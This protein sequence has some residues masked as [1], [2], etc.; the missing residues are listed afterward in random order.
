[1]TSLLYAEHELSELGLLASQ[2][3]CTVFLQHFL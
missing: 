3:L 1:M 2:F